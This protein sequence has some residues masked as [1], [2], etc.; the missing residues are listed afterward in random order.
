M[1]QP[2]FKDMYL[3]QLEYPTVDPHGWTAERSR[4]GLRCAEKEFEQWVY[5]IDDAFNVFH[6]A[7]KLLSGKG[8]H[9]RT[10]AYISK[11]NACKGI[12]EKVIDLFVK[13]K[14]NARLKHVNATL[15]KYGKKNQRD[16]LKTA[17]YIY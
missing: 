9:G 7:D 11:T 3:L 13:I 10:S 6:P 4:G 17:H 1:F 8:V 5:A 2:Q 14:I 16:Y 12:P 15:P